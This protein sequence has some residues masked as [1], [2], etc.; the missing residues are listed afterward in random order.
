MQALYT[1]ISVCSVSLLFDHTRFVSWES[2]VTAFPI[3][4][5]SSLLRERLNVMI[6]PGVQTH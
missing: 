1:L 6:D 3:H 5:L 4:L 2:A